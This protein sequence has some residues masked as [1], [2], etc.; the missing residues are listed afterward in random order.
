MCTKKKSWM[1]ETLNLLNFVDRSTDIK[2]LFIKTFF[3]VFMDLFDTFWCYLNLLDLKKYFLVIWESPITCPL[4]LSS[5]T[6][7]TATATTPPPANSPN[8]HSRIIEW[9]DSGLVVIIFSLFSS[10]FQTYL[11]C[12]RK[13]YKSRHIYFI[14]LTTPYITYF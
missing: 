8:M 2:S 14:L 7:T 12:T 3:F 11:L 1:Q 9:G 10:M 6:K 4:P 5:V 13:S